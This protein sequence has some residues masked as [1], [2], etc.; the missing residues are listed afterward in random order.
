[1][2]R[3]WVSLYLSLKYVLYDSLLTLCSLTGSWRNKCLMCSCHSK[4]GIN[5]LETSMSSENIKVC[6]DQSTSDFRRNQIWSRLWSKR[7]SGGLISLMTDIYDFIGY[8]K[9]IHKEAQRVSCCVWECFLQSNQ[10]Q[11]VFYHLKWIQTKIYT[12]LWTWTLRF[13]HFW[14]FTLS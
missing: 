11:D 9:E 10:H 8:W 4:V 6:S 12:D 14:C 1:M 7:W 3:V 5:S 2:F 13:Q